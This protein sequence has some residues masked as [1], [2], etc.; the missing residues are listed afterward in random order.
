MSKKTIHVKT[1]KVVGHDSKQMP[2][3]EKRTQK[4]AEFGV[5]DLFCENFLSHGYLDAEVVGVY[6][7]DKDKKDEFLDDEKSL[8]PYIK[9]LEAAKTK[10]VG[11]E[12]IDYKA[13]LEKE[14][15][16]SE[17]QSNLL[18]AMMER[19]E[20]LENKEEK[21][22]LAELKAEAKELGVSLTGCKTEESI[23]K[24]IEDKK[25]ELEG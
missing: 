9:M 1:S 5:F 4:L 25:K 8:L 20:K 17:A 13:E 15:A 21:D 23:Q 22:P 10:K 12:R 19:L 11:E 14:K 6:I 18:K 16:K 2:T 3:F 7:Q 24:K